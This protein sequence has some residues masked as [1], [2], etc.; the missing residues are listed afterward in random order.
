MFTA[1]L[2]LSNNFK[3]TGSSFKALGIPETYLVNRS[4]KM[5]TGKDILFPIQPRSADL[6]IPYNTQNITKNF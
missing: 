3:H 4:E 1:F 6:G 5:Q 2:L